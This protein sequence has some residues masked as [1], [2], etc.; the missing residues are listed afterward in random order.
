[1]WRAVRLANVNGRAH[2]VLDGR[3][4]DVEAASGGALS[5]D[6]MAHIGSLEALADLPVAD[7]APAAEGARLDAPVPRPPKVLAIGLNYRRHAEETGFEI[8][9]EPVVFAKL[10]NSICGPTDT[11]IIPPETPEI[12]WEVELV[13]VIGKSGAQI[14][15]A[16]AWDHVAGFTCGQDISDRAEQ[17]RAAKQFTY[18]KSYDTFA[19]IG[20]YVVTLDELDDPSDLR[21]VTTID[22]ET[23]QDSRTSDFIF[24]IP[25]VI[26]WLTRYMTLEAGDLIFTGTPEGVGMA[27]DPP[28]Y[29]APGMVLGTEIEGV[30]AML[31]PCA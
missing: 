5:S 10:T 3:L 31:N 15:A 28:R 21:V 4:V 22:G 19:P 16:N 14:A 11:I 30:G 8:P 23:V 17:F 2:A 24:T 6:P 18:A 13:V 20:P 1:M 27:L 9:D 26:E 12:D 25:E 29:L 7:D